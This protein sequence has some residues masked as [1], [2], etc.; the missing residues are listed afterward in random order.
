[1]A[2]KSAAVS[3]LF[4][5]NLADERGNVMIGFETSKREPLLKEDR[6]FYQ[7]RL[8]AIVPSTATRSARSPRPASTSLPTNPANIGVVNSI[9][10]NQPAGVPA[11]TNN[12]VFFMNSD[13]TVYKSQAAAQY[14]YNGAFADDDGTVWRK[15]NRD[16]ALQQNQPFIVAQLPLDRYSIFARAAYAADGQHPHLRTGH[17]SPT[18]A[19]RPTG[20][21]RCT[22][23]VGARPC[24]TAT[25]SMHRRS[26]P[27]GNTLA[28]YLSG[29][30]YGLDCPAIGGCTKSQA[31]PK[32][33]EVQRL[34]D[35]RPNRELPVTIAH[36]PNYLGPKTLSND[37]TSI[38]LMAGLE[39]E[40]PERDWTWELYTSRGTTRT[41][42]ADRWHDPSRG[43]FRWLVNQPNYGQGLQYTGNGSA[44]A[45]A[46]A[47]SIAPAACRSSTASTAGSNRASRSWTRRKAFR[48]QDCRTTLIAK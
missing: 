17:S 23:A 15:L 16:G 31:F 42:S 20:P 27:G 39:G 33:L 47:R 5:S 10:N 43:L 2:P 1:M 18:R 26:G 37:V 24:R 9:F 40:F 21:S 34:L 4:G 12:G 44:A 3:A 45:S 14:R 19:A 6:D 29:G 11:V 46:P 22:S 25:R 36:V 30:L 28:P 7:T 48:A 35:S 8:R 13:G 32:P 41:R 38:Q